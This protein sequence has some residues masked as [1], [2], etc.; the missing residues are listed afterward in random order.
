MPKTFISFVSYEKHHAFRFGLNLLLYI[1][2]IKLWTPEMGENPK[3]KLSW[4]QRLVTAMS[5]MTISR[6]SSCKLV[7]DGAKN[8]FLEYSRTFLSGCFMRLE[9]RPTNKVVMTEVYFSCNFL[10]ALLFLLKHNCTWYFILNDASMMC[11]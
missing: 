5:S 6:V 3:A 2:D 9:C 1:I 11:F 7:F 4:R 10:A 8:T